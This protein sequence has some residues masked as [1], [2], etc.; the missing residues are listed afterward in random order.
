MTL[1]CRGEVSGLGIVDEHDPCKVVDFFIVEQTCTGGSTDMDQTA[2]ANLFADMRD[3][4]ISPSR[5]R[6]WWHS[7]AAMKTF[8]SGTDEDNVERYAS[9]KALWSVV[10]NHEDAKRVAAGK[11]PTEMYIRID[12]FD[13]DQP[14]NTNSPMR[15]TIEG[16]DWHVAPL[17]V[18]GDEW[19]EEAMKSVKTPAPQKLDI[20]P[21]SQSQTDPRKWMQAQGRGYQYQG[22]QVR[23]PLPEPNVIDREDHDWRP[24][25]IQDWSKGMQPAHQDEAQNTIIAHYAIDEFLDLD[26]ISIETAMLLSAGWESGEMT[27]AQIYNSLVKSWD[28]FCTAHESPT[29]ADVILLRKTWAEVKETLQTFSEEIRDRAA[30]AAPVEVDTGSL[31]VQL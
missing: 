23:D 25:W 22:W 28:K 18:V 6:V 13:P 7:H 16:C 9:E 10:T 3:K 17:T 19:F 2:V 1:R 24:D 15:Y 5:W 26:V 11:S 8:F 12:L 30:A 20:K 4:G 27:D 31:V 21:I 14:K 29:T